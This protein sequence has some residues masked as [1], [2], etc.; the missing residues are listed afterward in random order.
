MVIDTQ[1]YEL[2]VLEGFEE[3]LNE[4]SYIYTEISSKSLYEDD[5]LVTDLDN[6][7]KTRGLQEL[8]RDGRAT[9]RK[10]LYIKS[11]TLNI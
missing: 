1:G 9:S 10:R 7:L 11:T 2:R 5:V 8:K 3:K 4:F 6:Y